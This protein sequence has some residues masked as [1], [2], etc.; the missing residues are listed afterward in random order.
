VNLDN[1][2]PGFDF[3]AWRT[4]KLSRQGIYN[5]G[6]AN[7]QVMLCTVDMYRNL[8][9]QIAHFGVDLSVHHPYIAPWHGMDR[10]HSSQ[11]LHPDPLVRARSYEWLEDSLERAAQTDARFVV[12]HI[13]DSRE[14]L[15][16]VS[17]QALACEAAD[18]LS[19]ASERYSMEIHIEFL[20]YHPSFHHPQH[21]SEVFQAQPRLKLC[22]DTGH[23]HRWTQIHEGDEIAATELL[24]PHLGS[25]HIWNVSSGDE[26]AASG[27][28]PVHP[29]HSVND[30]YA[31]IEAICKTALR[32]NPEASIIFE[33]TIREETSETFVTEGIAWV[34]EFLGR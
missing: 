9:K 31:D 8:A 27:H 32:S 1:L 13:A 6:L 25:M 33:P 4:A 16:F 3:E 21:F 11:F 28:I 15:H 5:V 2:W 7:W 20:G 29:S 24:A 19:K 10:Q 14:P 18:L 26:F 34:Q 23:L 17:A 22:L 12:T 30:G